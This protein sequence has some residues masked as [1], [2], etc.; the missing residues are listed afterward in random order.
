MMV[1]WLPLP[2][3]LMLR[4]LFVFFFKL[5]F[6]IHKSFKKCWVNSTPFSSETY[7]L[8][9]TC[10]SCFFYKLIHKLFFPKRKSSISLK[11]KIKKEGKSPIS[12]LPQ[13]SQKQTP[14]AVKLLGPLLTPLTDCSQP[15]LLL[16]P[17]SSQHWTGISLGLTAW[18]LGKK[19]TLVFSLLLVLF[20]NLADPL[21]YSRFFSYIRIIC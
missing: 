10:T 9:T 3:Q 20:N 17:Y 11:K 14:C 2:Q 16:L 18:K 5:E 6:H 21:S 1:A 12:A 15:C 19:G 4:Q 8:K 7:F 13:C